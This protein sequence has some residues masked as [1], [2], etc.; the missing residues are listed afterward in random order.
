MGGGGGGLNLNY[1]FRV[2]DRDTI[3]W[4]AFLTCHKLLI[5]WE[6]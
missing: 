1:S 4:L 6:L 3:S 5:W 2:V